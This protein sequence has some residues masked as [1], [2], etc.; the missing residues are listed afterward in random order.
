VPEGT[1]N[2]TFADQFN[3]SYVGY[4]PPQ[5][6][7][8]MVYDLDTFNHSNPLLKYGPPHFDFRLIQDYKNSL[9]SDTAIWVTSL[10]I[11]YRMTAHIS[12]NWRKRD[13]PYEIEGVVF[14]YFFLHTFQEVF[15]QFTRDPDKIFLVEKR[16][17][18][19]VMGSGKA[20]ISRIEPVTQVRV[21]ITAKQS[22]VSYIRDTMIDI[23]KHHA[24]G[25][26]NINKIPLS[27]FVDS[28]GVRLLYTA[29]SI[30][31][32]GNYEML[33]I[34]VVEYDEIFGSV[35]RG[36]MI[37]VF[38]SVGLIAISF[39]ASFIFICIVVYPLN[40]LGREMRK[41]EKMELRNIS[42]AGYSPIYEIRHLQIVFM[43]T[44]TKLMEYR[45]F[46]PFHLR[47][48]ILLREQGRDVL[49][50]D[51]HSFSHSSRSTSS[52]SSSSNFSSGSHSSSDS[53]SSREPTLLSVREIADAFN[54]HLNHGMLHV[55]LF[56]RI[57]NVEDLIMNLGVDFFTTTIYATLF[58]LIYE[59]LST[60][61]K[62]GGLFKFDLES[63]CI[64][65]T[66]TRNRKPGTLERESIKI[67]RLIWR[68][69]TVESV[70]KNVRFQIII[71]AAP[72][73]VGVIGNADIKNNAI[74]GPS[75]FP[76]SNKG[77]PQ[78]ISELTQQQ[79]LHNNNGL[80]F[81]LILH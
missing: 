30:S 58:R 41:V 9:V 59:V 38:V 4:L 33:S 72:I 57:L 27:Q 20:E 16:N 26:G 18:Y 63:V 10:D 56:F 42:I 35:D 62:T 2:Y 25:I 51:S 61:S 36:N 5:P 76:L 78:C 17:G 67:A 80:S 48:G 81:L 3:V 11:F 37:A 8:F 34:F 14:C 64:L 13:F 54:T 19:M 1:Q 79:L 43:K 44:V 69:L 6:T 47:G 31:I 53:S 68:R 75:F 66:D 50:S 40:M 77:G 39:V 12:R 55:S 15:E 73:A 29:Q 23:E 52:H 70:L 74:Y 49:S 32:T 22:D 71:H 60:R 65:F 28:K 24:G 45:S 46:L 21:R 7:Y